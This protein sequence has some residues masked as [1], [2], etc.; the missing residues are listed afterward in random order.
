VYN[1][2]IQ[3]QVTHMRNG[4]DQPYTGL[5]QDQVHDLNMKLYDLIQSLEY[6]V[7]APDLHNALQIN[8]GWFEMRDVALDEF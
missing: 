8:L 6:K 1:S 5:T 7:D 3:T 2:N 4:L